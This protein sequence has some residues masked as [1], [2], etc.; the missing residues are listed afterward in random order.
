VIRLTPERAQLGLGWYLRHHSLLDLFVKLGRG[1]GLVVG[2]CVYTAGFGGENAAVR[3]TTGL[4]VV[5]LAVLGLRRRWRAGHRLEVVAV[6]ST[7]LLF[8]AALVLAASGAPGPQPRYVLPYVLLLV[9]FAVHQAIE[10]FWPGLEVWIAGRLP[11][12]S[13]RSVALV[14]VG[15]WLAVRLAAAAPAALRDPRRFYA[16]EPRA[17]QT[18]L[19]LSEHLRPGETFALPFES[20]YSTWD[21]PR[22][23]LDPRFGIWLGLPA[24]DLR[25][26]LGELRIDKVVI[27]RTDAG[28]PGYGDKLGPAADAQG[29]LAFLD[30]PRCFAD[31]GQPSRYLIY[32]RP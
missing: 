23:D 9:P 17:H 5:A 6:G 21:L 4:L 26:Y 20:Y 14:V 7:V 25:R 12:R 30:W 32:C 19:W 8:S 3:V 16:V 10:R 29:P 31:S 28:A 24:G 15:L 11:R 22:P 18:S 1:V 13:A 2:L 27:D